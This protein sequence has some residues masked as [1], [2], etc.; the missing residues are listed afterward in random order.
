MCAKGPVVRSVVQIVNI[1]KTVT[2]CLEVLTKSA[3]DKPK[4]NEFILYLVPS[5]IIL[6]NARITTVATND[7][8]S[9]IGATPKEPLTYLGE[10]LISKS[11]N[12]VDLKVMLTQA[13]SQCKL[14]EKQGPSSPK[15]QPHVLRSK[16]GS[17]ASSK[18]NKGSQLGSSTIFEGSDDDVSLTGTTRSKAKPSLSRQS[19]TASLASMDSGTTA[20]TASNSNQS[21]KNNKKT[22][23]SAKQTPKK[24][25]KS[26]P[27]NAPK[28]A[29]SS[30]STS[31]SPLTEDNLDSSSP[32]ALEYDV[33]NNTSNDDH[34]S[35][36]QSD[37]AAILSRLGG[38]GGAGGS[39]ADSSSSVSSGVDGDGLELG[40]ESNSSKSNSL[41]L[42]T[43]RFQD[44][45]SNNASSSGADDAPVAL[46]IY[47][48]RDGFVRWS[49]SGP[50]ACS[51]EK[52]R[53]F[54]SYKSGAI[55]LVHDANTGS[56][57]LMDTRGRCLLVIH[58]GFTAKILDIKGNTTREY[59]K[60]E[61]VAA[62][63]DP[64]PMPH[65][66]NVEGLKMEFK[67]AQWEVRS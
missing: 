31:T 1:I 19:S 60:E 13:K 47:G 41:P 20:N 24:T 67:P 54:A 14:N 61:A 6:D 25:P 5:L 57:S 64:S 15:K 23:K 58:N 3:D 43:I 8:G 37:I 44:P 34:L 55:A 56:G 22:P 16:S 27:K 2:F 42:T 40:G 30:S 51:L 33:E 17:S 35:N 26:A 49:R 39:I 66:W 45:K 32:S 65:I 50:Q 38:G 21:S 11:A 63:G 29:L 59:S 7:L 12:L 36:A 18:N 52:G 46:C 48:N 9:T 28:T 10:T 4:L 62:A 53:L